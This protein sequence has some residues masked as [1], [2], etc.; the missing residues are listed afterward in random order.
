M[1]K[2]RVT[3]TLY[4]S[5]QKR[6]RGL[7]YHLTVFTAVLSFLKGAMNYLHMVMTAGLTLTA[8]EK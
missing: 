1:R 7:C 5:E 2:V 6:H 8:M 3:I 4:S